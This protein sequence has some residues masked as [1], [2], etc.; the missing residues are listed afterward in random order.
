MSG[1]LR[2]NAPPDLRTLYAPPSIRHSVAQPVCNLEPPTRKISSPV[3]SFASVSPL[4]KP[5]NPRIAVLAHN[6]E[7]ALTIYCLGKEMLLTTS[8]AT[9]P[10]SEYLTEF[11]CFCA[12]SNPLMP[13]AFSD[14]YAHAPPYSPQIP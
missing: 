6:V 5:F 3:A 4:A 9:A 10:P 1:C 11:V 7:A 2:T 13:A 14:A 8:A 12:V